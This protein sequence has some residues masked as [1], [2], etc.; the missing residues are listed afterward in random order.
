MKTSSMKTSSVAYSLLIVA[1]GA[2]SASGEDPQ[3]LEEQMRVFERRL[4]QLER[5]SLVEQVGVVNLTILP[6]ETWAGATVKFERPQEEPAIVLTGE[7]GTAG[8]WV[9][10]KS[11]VIT[12]D[13]FRVLAMFWNNKPFSEPYNTRVGYVV[14]RANPVAKKLASQVKPAQDGI[15]PATPAQ[16]LATSQLG[17]PTPVSHQMTKT[18]QKRLDRL[19]KLFPK[20][21]ENGIAE[22]IIEYHLVLK[23][24]E[25]KKVD[26]LKITDLLIRA[27]PSNR[28]IW[29]LDQVGTMLITILMTNEEEND[30]SFN[31]AADETRKAFEAM[32]PKR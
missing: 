25:G 18:F 27:T 4:V 21:S 30:K 32:G 22:L 5:S 24:E 23:E 20:K 3:A 15:K 7:T 8:S 17:N 1:V 11:Q 13:D 14:L 19:R 31:S 26:V 2:F 28:K 10:T 29:S 9:F 16:K 12:R 6:G